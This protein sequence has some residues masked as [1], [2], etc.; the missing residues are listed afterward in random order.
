MAGIES[1]DLSKSSPSST[2]GITLSGTSGAG[3]HSNGT[4]SCWRIHSVGGFI[5]FTYPGSP[6]STGKLAKDAFAEN[7]LIMNIVDNRRFYELKDRIDQLRRRRAAA[8]DGR[9]S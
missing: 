2:G 6:E 3:Y 9:Q 5:K 8:G 7:S 1:I 4:D